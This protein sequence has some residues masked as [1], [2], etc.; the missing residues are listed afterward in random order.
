MKLVELFQ[1]GK[2]S[3]TDMDQNGYTVLAHLAEFLGLR[4]D[5]DDDFCMQAARDMLLD[6][7]SR[8][9]LSDQ[10]NLLG[11]TA[12]DALA[13]AFLRHPQLQH[14]LR[15]G[16]KLPLAF[17]E[18]FS[19]ILEPCGYMKYTSACLTDHLGIFHGWRIWYDAI[20][21]GQHLFSIDRYA[22]CPEILEPLIQHDLQLLDSILV[23]TSRLEPYDFLTYVTWPEGLD[24]LLRAGLD[25]PYFL[26]TALV[27]DCAESAMLILARRQISIGKEELAAACFTSNP[28]LMQLVVD[29]LEEERKEL[30]CAVESCLSTSELGQLNMAHT[31]YF[32]SKA[33]KA[34]RALN[35][36]RVPFR[37]DDNIE[38]HFD[39]LIYSPLGSCAMAEM[40]WAAGFRN[41]NDVDS[42][43]R[44]SLM[45]CV[46]LNY[47]DWLIAHGADIHN[48]RKG[49]PALHYMVQNMLCYHNSN[50]TR[51]TAENELSAGS[52]RCARLIFEDSSR[53]N[54]QC[55]C[56]PSGCLAATRFLKIFL[57]SKWA[58]TGYRALLDEMLA[59]GQVDTI[60]THASTLIRFVI[61]HLL[62]IPHIC[63]HCDTGEDV[64]KIDLE[65]LKQIYDEH[66]ENL[67]L[68]EE[69]V[70]YFTLIYE[71]SDRPLVCSATQEDLQ[72]VRELG[73]IL[74]EVECPSGAVE[75]E[76]KDGS[77]S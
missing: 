62:E 40:L 4:I 24:T 69:L 5:F 12:G 43:G 2:A 74:D 8:G 32:T 16:K 18:I 72:R 39:W 38:K 41:I 51:K 14:H 30:Q 55:P 36:R 35:N 71:A 47:A 50:W 9:M 58:D 17:M 7:L 15:G 29:A 49:S 6:L 73:V 57:L 54:C 19:T 65:E 42:D 10:P 20:Q 63:R 31:D 25:A 1:D 13:N 61:F 66:D 59:L 27:A 70:P 21:L 11:D 3:P 64:D 28:V 76:E 53:D 23:S 60:D 56:S 52:R 46:T 22:A 67:R 26:V 68:L 44:T 37:K 34:Y 45:D 77:K 33:S 75:D 48:R